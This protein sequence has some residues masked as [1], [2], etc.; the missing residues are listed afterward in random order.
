MKHLKEFEKL[1]GLVERLIESNR[2]CRFQ[3]SRLTKE[4]LKLEQQIDQ[5]GEVPE[6]IDKD[7]LNQLLTENERLKN[8]N[9]TVRDQISIIVSD[10]ERR[11][12]GQNTG[13]DSLKKEN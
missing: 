5:L 8:K 13:V 2:E 3:V 9:L 11:L 12:V 1:K 10:L 7:Y 4:N 6:G